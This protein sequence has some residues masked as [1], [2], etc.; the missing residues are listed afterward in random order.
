MLADAALPQQSTNWDAI[1]AEVNAWRGAC[2]HHFSAVEMSVSETL[3]ALS[4]AAPSGTDVLLPHLFG[5]KLEQLV[6][7]TA[8]D[9]PFSEIGKNAQWELQQYRE[10][11]DNFRNYICHAFLKIAVERSG[12]WML[13]MRL[14]SF[15][16]G[17]ADR[18]TLALEQAEALA[19]L[20][21]LKR[22]GQ[23]LASVLG[24]LRKTVAA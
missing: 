4:D 12:Q 16:S 14:L 1:L 2:L 21:A 9:G 15:S 19:K 5:P 22:D 24:N 7:L 8:A 10:H 17:R 6:S 11:H 18:K 23:R 20:D 3:L 13:A